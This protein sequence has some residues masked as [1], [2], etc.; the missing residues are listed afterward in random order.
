MSHA[1]KR[2]VGPDAPTDL[3]AGPAPS[4]GDLPAR[5]RFYLVVRRG[6][7]AEVIDLRVGEEVVVGRSEDAAISIDEA[8]VSRRH[9]RILCSDDGV[10]VE[11]LGSRNGTLLNGVA[12]R[13]ASR[14]LASGDV[15]HVGS[16][17]IALGSTA[18]W[19]P[20]PDRASEPA[21]LAVDGMV[22]A[23]A[24]MV[25]VVR[26]AQRLA[27]ASGV[28]LLLGETGVG[29]EVF[30]ERIHAWSPR[31]EGPL[32]R[33]NCASLPENL[34]ETEL[35]GHEKGAF[36]GAD[37][38]KIGY[39]EAAHRGTLLLDETGEL[40][41]SMQ[42]KLLRVLETK[43]LCRV[44][45]TEELEIDVRILC[46]T[47]RDLEAEVACGRFR[48]DLY[49]RINTFVLRIPALRERPT[50]VSLLAELFARQLTEAGAAARAKGMPRFDGP[51]MSALL[52]YPWPGNVREL[53]NAVEH[54][55]V[56]CDGEMIR[57]EHLPAAV[58]EGAARS[59]QSDAGGVKGELAELERSRIGEALSKHGG[60]QTHAARSL[61]ISRRALI[62]KMQKYGLGSK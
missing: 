9:A 22:V 25:R 39:L 29:K 2:P 33:L 35:F 17:E 62:Y 28:V 11:D 36:T 61:G 27:K 23:D 46:A 38:R 1:P 40:P 60:N 41:A 10:R 3:D 14:A 55:I 20:S 30:A 42:V 21:E 19:D 57:T 44:G 24:A 51:A 54:A 8:R 48:E 50:E 58:R 16:L 34:L 52:R 47:H 49:Y 26:M 53:K 12:L 15:I 18:G 32:V 37:R 6:D 5:E 13:S 43:R 59:S 56:M 45:G 7:L 31:S 4:V